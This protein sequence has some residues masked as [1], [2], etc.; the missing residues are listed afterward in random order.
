MYR[1]HSDTCYIQLLTNPIV[2][3]DN[4]K[5]NVPKIK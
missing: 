4:H 5:Q 3:E 1:N 2:V